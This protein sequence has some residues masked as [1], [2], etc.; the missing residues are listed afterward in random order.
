MKHAIIK[1]SKQLS[2]MFITISGEYI[3]S[4]KGTKSDEKYNDLT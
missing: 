4:K 2:K 3:H 1:W